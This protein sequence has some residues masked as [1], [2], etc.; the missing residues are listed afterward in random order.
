MEDYGIVGHRRFVEDMD[1]RRPPA[2]RG[3]HGAW[4]MGNKTPKDLAPPAKSGGFCPPAKSTNTRIFLKG[5]HWAADGVVPTPRIATM[6]KPDE[7]EGTREDFTLLDAVVE[8]GLSTGMALRACNLPDSNVCQETRKSSKQKHTAWLNEKSA[9][10][11]TIMKHV[12]A[13][14]E[15]IAAF[16]EKKPEEAR[17]RHEGF[18]TDDSK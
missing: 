7:V 16:S 1:G 10:L 17:T 18:P 14:M 11:P 12:D 8:Q 3:R 5:H 6:S 13:S 4:C 9:T 15:A 2:P